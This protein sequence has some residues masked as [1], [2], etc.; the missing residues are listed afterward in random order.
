MAWTTENKSS[1]STCTNENKSSTS[2]GTLNQVKAGLGWL[3]NHLNL[4]YNEEN[5]PV[6]GDAV[7]YNGI[8]YAV[9]WTNQNKS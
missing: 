4:T 9:V 1:A 8:G 7:L 5:D 3:Y 2:W 6:S